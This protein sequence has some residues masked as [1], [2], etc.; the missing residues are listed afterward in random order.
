MHTADSVSVFTESLMM[1]RFTLY[2]DAVAYHKHTVFSSHVLSL[3][4]SRCTIHTD[5]LVFH[6]H[7]AGS[8]PVVLYV[9][10]NIWVDFYFLF[11]F[12]LKIVFEQFFLSC[13]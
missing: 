10:D 3:T 6:V 2:T 12:V 1:S 9:N 4:I 13:K 11:G 8:V 7:T 5:G